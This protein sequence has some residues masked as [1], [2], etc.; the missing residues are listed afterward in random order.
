MKSLSSFCT[1]RLWVLPI[2]ALL[3]VSM[4]AMPIAFASGSDMFRTGPRD[5]IVK[6][7]LARPAQVEVIHRA[8]L[9]EIDK[10]W[11]Q[12]L[13]T[14]SFAE[15][16]SAGHLMLGPLRLFSYDVV[17]PGGTFALHAHDNVEVITVVLEGSFEHEDTAGH[18][19]RAGVGDLMLMSAGR[20]VKHTEQ[21][22]ADALTRV[23]TIWLEPRT[24][25]TEPHHVISRLAATNGWQVIAAERDAPLAVDQD[26]RVLIRRFAPGEHLLFEAPPGRVVYLGIVEGELVTNG[27]RVGVPERII[28]R[29]GALNIASN[30][31]ATVVLVDLPQS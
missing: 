19:G 23:V 22:D 3:S 2:I 21:A 15:P 4:L 20:G 10:G 1:G 13:Y 8:Q 7:A 28:A 6:F 30:S 29:N 27:Q 18:S 31:G 14:A 17:Q 12:A 16:G 26:A 24:R 25:D 11:W 9:A 5:A